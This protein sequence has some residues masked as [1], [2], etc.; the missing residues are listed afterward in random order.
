MGSKTEFG[1]T[2]YHESPEMWVKVS[3]PWML[4][5]LLVRVS[6]LTSYRSKVSRRH[7]E[8]GQALHTRESFPM[9]FCNP[10]APLCPAW[11]SLFICGL[12]RAEFSW[13][14]KVYSF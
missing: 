7:V 1:P 3:A 8:T 2:V 12:P 13:F 14:I 6:D 4:I 10:P 5:T 9:S 11:V